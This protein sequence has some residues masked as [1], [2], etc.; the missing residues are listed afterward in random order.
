MFHHLYWLLVLIAHQK[1]ACIHVSAARSTFALCL[2]CKDQNNDLNEWIEY[3]QALGVNNIIML[4][5][6][7][8]RPLLLDITHHVAS[9]FVIE[10]LYSGI[11][12]KPNNQ[13]YAY[14]S[15][16][17]KFK[18]TF[19]YIGFI[20]TDEFIV[21]TNKSTN[22]IDILDRYSYAGG[23]TL[24]W[25]IFGSSGHIQRPTGG[26]L[27]NYHSCVKNCHIKTIIHTK[28]TASTSE[29]VHHFLYNPG[30]FAVDTS[31]NHVASQFNPPR[32][33][34]LGS[35][36][37]FHAG[38]D[39]YS[40]PPALFDVMYLNHYMTKSLEDFREKQERGLIHQRS[41]PNGNKAR[42]PSF[43]QEI[44]EAATDTCEPLVMPTMKR[45]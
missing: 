41:Q 21:V 34:G 32:S 4:D 19:T 8:S 6:N 1:A 24:N 10:Y 3:H 43:F 11:S 28:Y 12:Y 18:D 5:D 45:L 15:C 35:K 29:G 42:P 36:S 14:W 33:D 37:L 39:C 13:L 9:G 2:I 20:D 40:P 25:M 16:L 7:S 23:L 26:V 31:H 27:A 38:S 22:V 17:Q 44:D 30:Y